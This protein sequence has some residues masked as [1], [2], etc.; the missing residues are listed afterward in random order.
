MSPSNIRRNI[1][2]LSSSA[3]CEMNQNYTK[4]LP[5]KMYKIPWDL[6]PTRRTIVYRGEREQEMWPS[7]EKSTPIGCQVSNGQPWKHTYKKHYMDWTSS[8]ATTILIYQAILIYHLIV[9]LKKEIMNLKESRES[10]MGVFEER[11]RK[12]K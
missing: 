2:K 11:K 12:K 10:Y 8:Y 7:P 3:K 9:D 1:H 5:N 6:S 4:I